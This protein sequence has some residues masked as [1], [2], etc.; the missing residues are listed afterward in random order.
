MS[1]Y[2][3]MTNWRSIENEQQ[4]SRINDVIHEIHRDISKPLSAKYLAKIASYSE[5]HF[6][7]VFK[8]LVGE[9]V[10]VYIRRTRLEHAANQLML[11]SH[12][13][14]LEIAEKCGFVSLSSFS[15]VFKNYFNSTPG[16]WRVSNY[17]EHSS[18]YLRD[19]E[20]AAGA[21][22]VKRWVI[23]E[24]EITMLDPQLVAYIRHRGYGRSIKQVWQRLTAWGADECDMANTTQVGLYHSNPAWTPLDQCQYV[25]CLTIKKPILRRGAVSSLVIPGGLHAVFHMQGEYGELLPFIGKILEQWFPESGYKHQTTPAF[26]KYKKNQFLAADDKFDVRLCFPISLN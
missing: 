25:A 15:K 26:V 6:H 12:S 9:S 19:P 4:A 16:Q 3:L 7:R 23:P 22:R 17:Q 11:D 20:I 21:K 24:A 10:N 2:A 1:V 5:H 13:S 14:V 8:K 18:H